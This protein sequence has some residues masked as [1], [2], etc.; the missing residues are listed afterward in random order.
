MSKNPGLKKW[1]KFA[2]RW[3]I[4]VG[5]IWWVFSQITLRD[6]VLV[7]NAEKRPVTASLAARALES[8]PNFE[9]HDPATGQ[10]RVVTRQDVVNAPEKKNTWLTWRTPN[11]PVT[12]TLLALDLSENLR[13]VNGF[14]VEDPESHH[15]CWIRP[16]DL[17]QPY[18]LHVPHPRVEV[19]VL[20]L[21]SLANPTLLLLCVLIFPVNYVI[22][23]FRWH[24]LL[25][26]VG[27]HLGGGRVF[28]LNMVGSFYNTFIP[29]TTGGDVLKAYYASQHTTHRAHAVMSVVVDRLIGLVALIILGGI[30]S[31]WQY[32][33][34]DPANVA[35][36]QACGRVA[37]G[38]GVLVVLALIGVELLV[39]PTLSRVSGMAFLLR[40]LPMQRLVQSI[41][42][43]L[44]TYRTRWKLALG[45][46][47]VTF[48]VHIT[49]V[50]SA[51]LAGKAFG[52]PM[53]ATYYFVCVPV[54]VLVGAVPISPQGAGVMEF[55]AIALTRQYGV[56]VSQAF[57]L[58]MSIRFVQ[59][60]WN[61][62]GG[63]FVFRG[64]YHAPTEA[65]EKELQEEVDS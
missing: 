52:L 15:G 6:H 40:H 30:L 65:E 3:G 19:G 13:A 8:S 14:L 59:I 63:I 36:R 24:E 45:M 31:A 34:T 32:F 1:V 4:A 62:A 43:V 9:I 55:F 27:I 64:G 33:H 47:V 61:L 54:I 29:G 46:L 51:M 18:T 12:G 16:R 39:H 28:V 50:I 2:L 57:A 10:R 41:V 11:G 23:S 42:A 56:T 21:I 53:P 35:I 60:L 49:T 44:T 25:K 22:T 38:S 5:G 48:P 58:T 26:A 7:L 20:S 17:V 37:T